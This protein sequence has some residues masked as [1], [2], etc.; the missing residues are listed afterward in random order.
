MGKML[1]AIA[2]NSREVSFRG[3][4]KACS[5]PPPPLAKWFDSIRLV[6]GGH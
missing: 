4:L 6:R 3:A 5:S 2:S 1:T